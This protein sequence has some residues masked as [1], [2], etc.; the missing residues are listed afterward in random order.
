ME[1]SDRQALKCENVYL[2]SKLFKCLSVDIHLATIKCISWQ[3]NLISKC[4]YAS[5]FSSFLVHHFLQG[6]KLSSSEEDIGEVSDED[7]AIDIRFDREGSK[8]S[9][10]CKQLSDL[11][12]LQR[13][14]CYDF[15]K[16]LNSRKYT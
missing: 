14:R 11:V 2:L 10:L 4:H 12:Y 9:P 15:G 6:K 16:I 8:K 1:N 5:F 13:I 7:E 3:F